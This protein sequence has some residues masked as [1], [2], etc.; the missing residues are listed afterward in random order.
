[1]RPHAPVRRRRDGFS[2]IELTVV[3]ALTATV[4]IVAVPTL[5]SYWDSWSLQAAAR[6]LA[7]AIN[8]ARQ[9]AIATRSTVWVDVSG[10]NHRCRVCGVSC[11]VRTGPSAHQS[12]GI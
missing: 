10:T 4:T 3:L 6:A 2:L 7:T 11:V 8:L 9:L 12:V 5:L 1:M